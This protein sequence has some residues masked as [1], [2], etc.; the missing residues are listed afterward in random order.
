MSGGSAKS[1]ASMAGDSQLIDPNNMS[2][3]GIVAGLMGGTIPDA[4]VIRFALIRFE[5][6]HGRPATVRDVGIV[7]G[8]IPGGR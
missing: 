8:M 7:A 4:A 1:G 5:E 6:T 2:H 3:L